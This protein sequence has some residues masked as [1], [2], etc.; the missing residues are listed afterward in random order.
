M[1][2]LYEEQHPFTIPSSQFH[3]LQMVVDFF[4]FLLIML[5]ESK[6]RIT[7][8]TLGKTSYSWLDRLLFLGSVP[9]H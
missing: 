7:N 4:M 2:K 9:Y 1:I 6:S 5:F 8:F 3:K